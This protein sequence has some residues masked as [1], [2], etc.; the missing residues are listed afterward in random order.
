MDG[1]WKQ[2]WVHADFAQMVH[3]TMVTKRVWFC[4]E[5]GSP[6]KFVTNGCIFVVAAVDMGTSGDT[7][8]RLSATEFV[9]RMCRRFGVGTGLKQGSTRCGLCD[10]SRHVV[11][12]SL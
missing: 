6:A 3:G 10:D 12:L 4:K 7:M 9:L 5:Q 8:K 1:V 11:D 2:Q